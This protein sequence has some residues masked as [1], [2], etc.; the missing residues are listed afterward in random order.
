MW[1][2]GGSVLGRPCTTFVYHLLIKGVCRIP[3]YVASDGSLV[4]IV[5]YDR[6][7]YKKKVWYEIR[8]AQTAN[9]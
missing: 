7:K 6:G 8:L 1:L 9:I 4:F 5:G 2:L 3:G